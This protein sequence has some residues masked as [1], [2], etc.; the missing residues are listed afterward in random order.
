MKEKWKVIKNYSN[1]SCSKSGKIKNNY[2][3]RIFNP[4]PDA[5]GY[6]TINIKNDNGKNKHMGIH[7]YIAETLPGVC[8]GVY[9]D[10]CKLVRWGNLPEAELN[11]L[12]PPV[13]IHGKM[14]KLKDGQLKP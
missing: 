5:T 1:Y 7:R 4:K 10:G 8:H 13:R 6:L 12:Y 9:F 14:I 11:R 2:T 3:G